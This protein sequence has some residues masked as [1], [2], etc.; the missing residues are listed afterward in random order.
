MMVCN[1]LFDKCCEIVGKIGLYQEV[2]IVDVDGNI[3]VI[4]EKGE[5]CCWGYFVMKGYWGEEV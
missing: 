5:L 1:D 2:K 3:V 4:G